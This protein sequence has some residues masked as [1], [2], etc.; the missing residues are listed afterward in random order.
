MLGQLHLK[1]ALSSAGMARED[2]QDEGAAV[3]DLD[4]E[5]VFQIALLVGR[6]LVVED[7]QVALL[8]G[9]G[10]PDLFQLTLTHVVLRG[11]VQV[12]GHLGDD[13]CSHAHGELGKLRQGVLQAPG[14]RLPARGE[15]YQHRALRPSLG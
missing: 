3:D 13:V 2:V 9:D 12:L 5:V 10:L 6:E 11:S 14:G 15:A 8:V 7:R 4:L 1:A